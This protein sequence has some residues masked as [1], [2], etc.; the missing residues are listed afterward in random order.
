M[1]NE[2]KGDT[3]AAG[4]SPLDGKLDEVA[5]AMFPPVVPRKE[6]Q[7]KARKFRRAVRAVK[8]ALRQA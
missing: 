6:S 7:A 5:K 1:G 3:E 8:V 4:T 2:T